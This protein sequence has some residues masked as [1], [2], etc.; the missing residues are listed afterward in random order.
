MSAQGIAICFLFY[1]VLSL[2]GQWAVIHFGIE[3]ILFTHIRED[4]MREFQHKETR[5]QLRV[6]QNKIKE[7]ELEIG[8]ILAWKSDMEAGMMKAFGV[9]LVDGSAED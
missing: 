5:D 1:T 8:V 9:T 2:I 7:L 4:G 6:A 3:P